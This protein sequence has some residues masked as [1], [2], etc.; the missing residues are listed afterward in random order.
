MKNS[1]GTKFGQPDEKK[2]TQSPS[3]PKASAKTSAS[4]SPVKSPLSNT[5]TTAHEAEPKPTGTTSGTGTSNDPG[6]PATSAKSADTQASPDQVQ[7]QTRSD[8]A[9]TVAD[10][11]LA[12]NSTQSIE[13]AKA[14]LEAVQA[15]LDPNS[16]A[17]AEIQAKIDE[18]T[19]R[20]QALRPKVE[21]YAQAQ[22]MIVR[23]NF[24]QIQGLGDQAARQEKEKTSGVNPFPALPPAKSSDIPP[25]TRTQLR[26]MGEETTRQ[27]R[28]DLR[29]GRI[30]ALVDGSNF[31]GLD[32]TESVALMRVQQGLQEAGIPQDF[33]GASPTSR[34]EL[35]TLQATG[36][37]GTVANA[38][39]ITRELNAL[40][41]EHRQLN[42]RL[43]Q[44]GKEPVTLPALQQS[45]DRLTKLDQQI[46]EAGTQMTE[47]MGGVASRS[48]PPFQDVPILKSESPPNV[49][50][51]ITEIQSPDGPLKLVGPIPTRTIDGH[52]FTQTGDN[53]AGL[54][55][56]QSR[57]LGANLQQPLTETQTNELIRVNDSLNLLKGN[58]S[59]LS[60]KDIPM[61]P[62]LR[63]SLGIPDTLR[64]PDES[65]MGKMFE[66]TSK[67]IDRIALL[68]AEQRLDAV[69]RVSGQIRNETV[70]QQVKT[71]AIGENF[72]ASLIPRIIG[73]GGVPESFNEMAG[74]QR[75]STVDMLNLAGSAA[76]NNSFAQSLGM[77]RTANGYTAEQR[78]ENEGFHQMYQKTQMQSAQLINDSISGVA[79]AGLGS[80]ANAGRNVAS[81]EIQQFARQGLGQ[82]SQQQL[83]EVAKQEAATLARQQFQTV[84]KS[85]FNQLVRQQL[86]SLGRE[87]TQQIAAQ[88]SVQAASEK[89]KPGGSQGTTFTNATPPESTQ[90]AGLST[91][92]AAKDP[93]MVPPGKYYLSELDGLEIEVATDSTISIPDMGVPRGRMPLKDPKGV[94]IETFNEVYDG[95][96]NMSKPTQELAFPSLRQVRLEP[97]SL[98]SPTTMG[99]YYQPFR[100]VNVYFEKPQNIAQTLEHEVGHHVD[101]TLIR[102]P[103]PV[104]SS[105]PANTSAQSQTLYEQGVRSYLTKELGM[106]EAE[107]AKA[108][109]PGA[110]APQLTPFYQ[111]EITPGQISSLTTDRNSFV[112][113]MRNFLTQEMN[114]SPS[115]AD[116]FFQERYLLETPTAFRRDT[117]KFL[118]SNAAGGAPP[119]STSPANP[120]FQLPKTVEDAYNQI[121]FSLKNSGLSHSEQLEF[122]RTGQLPAPR[123]M[124]QLSPRDAS[125][126]NYLLSQKE[127][128][129]DSNRFA[130]SLKGKPLEQQVLRADDPRRLTLMQ[131]HFPELIQLMDQ[132]V[133]NNQALADQVDEAIRQQ[134]A[135]QIKQ[136][137]P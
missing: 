52:T 85:D 101:L 95:L 122:M 61:S 37:V 105:L 66:P 41:T 35:D 136:L 99:D 87:Q 81:Q 51:Q 24:T 6:N 46:T 74:I 67:A 44:M 53:T 42:E 123:S 49:A 76:A 34:E 129:A 103:G 79:M 120:Q 90:K 36:I 33:K 134:V 124:S 114:M 3:S 22:G 93:V 31:K 89:L 9:K 72:K 109:P 65:I 14:N 135:Q 97:Q 121:T 55:Q 108:F 82:L 25:A 38:K 71:Q 118:A 131:Q 28:Q 63:T 100:E 26:Q 78:A 116:Q 106:S 75:S 58:P 92:P 102:Q 21:G 111:S 84:A 47:K 94:P 10:T 88:K 56:L 86:G 130:Q 73:S 64:Q 16:V 112:S 83:K 113:D 5:S 11:A 128:M 18:L 17:A 40:Q 12:S 127:V 54:Q 80:L 19:T 70:S 59:G 13:T 1:N 45:I 133:F 29:D 57:S 119:V 30:S 7:D 15:S 32:G 20:S 104:S 125:H 60:I 4:P 77:L 96:N 68:P 27:L 62:E 91:A 110:S 115:Q 126:L 137:K 43:A 8:T 2:P 48:L 69:T 132:Q 50:G 39:G 117:A 23:N 107:V 98:D